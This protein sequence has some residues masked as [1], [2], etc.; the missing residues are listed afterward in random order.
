VFDTFTSIGLRHLCCKYVTFC[1]SLVTS[2]VQTDGRTDDSIMPTANHSA[3]CSTIRLKNIFTSN[4]IKALFSAG[5]H[6][7]NVTGA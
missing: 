4:E 5:L 7:V 2:H 3:C 6:T 1:A